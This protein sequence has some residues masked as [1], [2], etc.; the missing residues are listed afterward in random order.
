MADHPREER[1]LAT[2]GSF[3]GLWALTWLGASALGTSTAIQGGF[4]AG[5]LAAASGLATLWW[6]TRALESLADAAAEA[7]RE[8]RDAEDEEPEDANL[9]KETRLTRRGA[10][11]GK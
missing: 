5:G 9:V 6:K 10:Q 2:A 4:A 7:E 1:V 3:T 8:A 11:Q